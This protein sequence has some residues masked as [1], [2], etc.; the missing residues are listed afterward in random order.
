MSRMSDLAIT[1]RERRAT[2]AVLVP[3]RAPRFFK[4]RRLAQ[5]FAT[6]QRA[7][8]RPAFIFPEN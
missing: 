2:V 6:L 8:G 3:M 5:V 1:M 4:S 7:A